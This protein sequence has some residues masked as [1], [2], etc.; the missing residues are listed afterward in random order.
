MRKLMACV[1][2]DDRAGLASAARECARGGAPLH[3]DHR[4]IHTD[5]SERILHVE[6]RLVLDSDGG[7]AAVEGTAQDITERKRAEEQIR[8]LAYHDSLTGL[9]NRLLFKERLAMAI[10]TARR[11][12]WRAGVL[13]LDLDHFK[14]INDTLGH[15]VGD[16][17]LQGVADRLVASV[18]E[19]DVV[20]RDDMPSA[21]SRLGGDEFTILLE[22]WRT[23]KISPGRCILESL[24]T[25]HLRATV[26]ISGSIGI[27]AW[28]EMATTPRSHARRY[29]DTA[30]GTGRNNYLFGPVDERGGLRA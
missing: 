22:E 4:V 2:P 14:R 12:E 29:G 18:R 19:T 21:I 28:P 15:S 25:F 1:H 27:T 11:N 8:Y 5:G 20:A 17:L 6:A 13:F 16:A 9:G 3:S 10:A 7:A 24:H 30:R 26:V 23:R